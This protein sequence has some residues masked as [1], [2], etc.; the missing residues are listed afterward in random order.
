MTPP[1]DNPATGLLPRPAGAHGPIETLIA[2]HDGDVRAALRQVLG[3]SQEEDDL[4]QE[5]F[6]RLVVRLR[7]PGELCV[8][9]W[10]RGVAHNL[11]VDE[12]RRRRP[13]PVDD[14]RLDRQVPS[15]ADDV[16][17]GADLYSRVVRGA[18]E[19]PD[20]QRAAL[21]AALANGPGVAGVASTLGVSVHAAESL[22]SRARVGLRH[23]LASTGG[24]A[25]SA[26]L[27]LGVVVAAVA[28]VVAS[29]ARRWRLAVALTAAG[30]ALAG[31]ALVPA[32]HGGAAPAGRPAPEAVSA[33]VG[34]PAPA[35]VAPGTEPALAPSAA[36]GAAP[37]LGAAAGPA[38]GGAAGPG[39]G[40]DLPT[41][42]A[43]SVPV[44]VPTL[45]EALAPVLSAVP[46]V[47]LP[48]VGGVDA[49][50][51]PA[52]GAACGSVAELTGPASPLEC[53]TG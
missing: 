39:P 19:L 18:R 30:G 49:V 48:A 20:R 41:L 10:L 45:D 11:A 12:V 22:L 9:A 14:V 1:A 24:D 46:A 13:V 52:L 6:T 42:P 23:Q 44:A 17:A 16:I 36:A 40:V 28:A 29:V 15:A 7:Q 38:G 8:G 33:T 43:V 25:G 4:V 31:A 34:L 53:A 37:A 47:E 50:V 2:R 5:V 51:A 35:V 26:R 32:V 27:S 21:S 3:R